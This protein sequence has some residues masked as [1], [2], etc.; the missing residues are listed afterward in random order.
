MI[1]RR[2]QVQLKKEKKKTEGKSGPGYQEIRGCQEES[3]LAL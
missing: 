2:L 1:V 3:W